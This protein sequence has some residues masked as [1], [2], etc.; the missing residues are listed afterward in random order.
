MLEKQNTEIEAPEDISI[1]SL[2][3]RNLAQETTQKDL[4]E[5]FEKYGKIESIKY[6]KKLNMAYINF[7]MRENAENAL[8][9]TYGKLVLFD[10]KVSVAWA[11]SQK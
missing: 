3:L 9:E 6:I 10:Q 4:E 8:E 11:K 1:K 2:C 5:I 7:S